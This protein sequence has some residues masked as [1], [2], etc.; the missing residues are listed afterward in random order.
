MIGVWGVMSP[1]GV[2][3]EIWALEV[4]GCEDM[5]TWGCGVW[6]LGHGVL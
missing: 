1:G 2:E 4:W 5:G 3:C 6:G